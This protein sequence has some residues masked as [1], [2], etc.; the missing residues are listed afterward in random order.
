ML[1]YCNANAMFCYAHASLG[2]CYAYAMLVREATYGLMCE[3]DPDEFHDH[4]EFVKV[5]RV[6]CTTTNLFSVDLNQ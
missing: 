6:D 2:Q 1:C 4:S 5:C 3:R